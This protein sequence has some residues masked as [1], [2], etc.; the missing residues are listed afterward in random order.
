MGKVRITS[1]ECPKTEMDISLAHQNR[2]KKGL[3]G[4]GVYTDQCIKFCTE[5]RN[6]F[7][8]VRTETI[9]Y[10]KRYYTYNMMFLRDFPSYGKEKKTC[11]KCLGQEVIKIVQ[12]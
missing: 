8:I 5:C 2:I 7:E 1:D 6:C 4:E 10:G 3:D 11:P 12:Q 9:K